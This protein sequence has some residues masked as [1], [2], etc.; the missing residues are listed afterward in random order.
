MDTQEKIEQ[1]KLIELGELLRDVIDYD[2][3]IDLAGVDSLIRERKRL[4]EPLR[5]SVKEG[6]NNEPRG[7]G[8]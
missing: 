3:G 1:K 7:Y 4:K 6:N 8:E 2:E 5:Y